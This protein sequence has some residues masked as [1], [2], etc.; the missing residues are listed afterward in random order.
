MSKGLDDHRRRLKPYL[1][2]SHSRPSKVLQML[3]AHRDLPKLWGLQALDL[4]HAADILWSRGSA[5]AQR[6][7]AEIVA[8]LPDRAPGSGEDTLAQAHS[9]I[10]SGKML[11]GL[12]FENLIKGVLISRDPT[13]VDK[14]GIPAKRLQNHQFADR[15]RETGLLL[16]DDEHRLVKIL[17]LYVVWLGPYPSPLELESY[18]DLIGV[19]AGDDPLEID[20]AA[21]DALFDRLVHHPDMK[22]YP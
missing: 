13:L 22:W 19:E 17:E 2:S 15:A 21:A 6:H 5:G 7:W 20:K 1:A 16:T 18:H 12:A 3:L 11:L 10:D 8:E 9:L 4:K 14:N